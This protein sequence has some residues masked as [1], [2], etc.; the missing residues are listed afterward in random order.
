MDSRLE[1]Q[2]HPHGFGVS[3]PRLPSKQLDLKPAPSQSHRNILPPVRT[4][5]LIEQKGFYSELITTSAKPRLQSYTHGP[6]TQQSLLCQAGYEWNT[7]NVTTF[8][9][10]PELHSIVDKEKHGPTTQQSLLTDFPSSCYTA[11]VQLPYQC[12]HG[13]LPRKIEI[14]R[15]RREYLTMDLSELLAE[16][17]IDSNLLI[18]RHR[19]NVESTDKPND[20]AL[21]VSNYLTLE[22]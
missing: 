14:E 10:P 3:L 15:R 6:Q 7:P 21:S 1:K 2:N 17:G 19:I 8:C 13:K 16:Q 22:T 20:P 9:T 12:Q 18:P 5:P 4:Y 11:K